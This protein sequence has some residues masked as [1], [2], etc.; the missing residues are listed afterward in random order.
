M[1]RRR[2]PEWARLA[3]GLYVPPYLKFAPWYPCCVEGE[4]CCDGE[5]PPDEWQVVLA[6]IENI[7][8]K[9]GQCGTFNDTFVLPVWNV[10]SWGISC[11][12]QYQFDPNVCDIAALGLLVQKSFGVMKIYVGLIVWEF[13]TYSQ[14]L[15]IIDPHPGCSAISGEDVPFDYKSWA[16]CDPDS[17]PSTCT[18]TAL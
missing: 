8:G 13:H 15:K 17:N 7:G 11:W 9:C 10:G 4:D 1:F 14:W 16:E 5:A 12:W 6:G 2:K 3:S 18:V